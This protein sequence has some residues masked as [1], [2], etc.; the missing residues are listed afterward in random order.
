[1]RSTVITGVSRGLGTGLFRE[2]YRRGDRILALGRSFTGE[3]RDLAEV[4]PQRVRLRQADLRDPLSQPDT[5]ELLAFLG[6][7]TG[8]SVLIH[9]AAVVGPIGA[10]GALPSG[11]LADAFSVNLAA[12]AVLTNAFLAAAPAGPRHI[13]FISSGA[14]TRVVGGW[15][16]Y[17]ASKAGGEMFFRVLAE[18]FGHDAT[19]R[20]DC[21]NPGQMSTGM[22]E[23]IRGAGRAGAYFPQRQDWVDSYE[24]GRLAPPEDVAR[25]ILDE[26]LTDARDP[27]GRPPTRE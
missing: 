23:E 15:S 1:M 14:A 13:L 11:E 21:V 4:E 5:D 24:F 10:V 25:R 12:P 3:Q 6:T 27:R 19:V 8:T 7:G 26:Y 22:Q 20:V 18:Q 17:C 2:A 9:N 16:A